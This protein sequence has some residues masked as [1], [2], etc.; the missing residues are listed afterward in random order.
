MD[1]ETA[2]KEIEKLVKDYEELRNQY[3]QTGYDEQQFCT[4][5]LNKFFKALGWDVDN[6]ENKSE[7]YCDVSL[8]YRLRSEESTKFPITHLDIL[9]KLIPNSSLKQ[10]LHQ[11]HLKQK[12]PSSSNS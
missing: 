1:K 11:Q 5:V 7:Y 10:K 4:H 8:Q 12:R 3:G 2:K 9:L 6:V